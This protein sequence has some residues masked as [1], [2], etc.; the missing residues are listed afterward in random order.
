MMAI[1]IVQMLVADVV[2]AVVGLLVF[3]LVIAANIAFQRVQSPLMTRAQALR[4]EVSEV[5]H[6][7][8][9]GAMVVKTLGRESEE[10]EREGLSS[11]TESSS[12]A[13]RPCMPHRRS[14][15]RTI[16]D[17][18]RQRTGRD[19]R[20]ATSADGTDDP[21]SD[22]AVIVSDD[23]GSFGLDINDPWIYEQMWTRDWPWKKLKQVDV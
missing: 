6:E 18:G 10:T 16:L 22:P 2:M 13:W 8:F 5:A 23:R 7:S 20:G 15:R 17:S 11:H 12:R 1:A 21:P 3:P 9:D 4:A 14:S 19:R